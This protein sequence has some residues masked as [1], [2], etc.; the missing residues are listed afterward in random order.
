MFGAGPVN[1]LYSLQ[2]RANRAVTDWLFRADRWS[3]LYSAAANLVDCQEFAD[4]QEVGAVVIPNGAERR[5][6]SLCEAV[7]GS[8]VPIGAGGFKPPPRPKFRRPT[9]IVPNST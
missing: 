5:Q 1:T 9:K 7:V 3:S 6:V 4:D 2:L 8:G